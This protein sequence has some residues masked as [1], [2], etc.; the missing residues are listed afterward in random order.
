MTPPELGGSVLD[1]VASNNVLSTA[2]AGFVV[3]KYTYTILTSGGGA[4]T[5]DFGTPTR[6][7]IAFVTS[8]TPGSAAVAYWVLALVDS[9]QVT[10]VTLQG[11]SNGPTLI[12]TG[13]T[14]TQCELLTGY[15]HE[16]NALQDM[17]PFATITNNITIPYV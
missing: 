10:Q 15:G 12:Y 3:I 2:S 7:E 13:P 5:I 11:A 8:L 1:V 6:G 9:G 17:T 16:D 14:I 4:Q